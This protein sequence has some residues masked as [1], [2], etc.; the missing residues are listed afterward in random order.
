MHGRNSVPPSSP[1]HSGMW[2]WEFCQFQWASRSSPD[3]FMTHLAEPTNNSRPHKPRPATH[4]IM[5][6]LLAFVVRIQSS[7]QLIPFSITT[8]S[9]TRLGS[10]IGGGGGRIVDGNFAVNTHVKY[11]THSQV[12]TGCWWWV[13]L[14][15]VLLHVESRWKC[16][17]L[18][19]NKHWR[20]TID[21]GAI[22]LGVDANR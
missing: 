11:T 13:E 18:R 22:G 1:T 15:W 19:I 2:M 17:R 10:M 3:N 20:H 12:T 14:S 7:L 16:F 8:H 6:I 9:V 21:V 5:Q 4:R